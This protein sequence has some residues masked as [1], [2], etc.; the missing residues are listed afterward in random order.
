LLTAN[1]EKETTL[2]DIAQPDPA[3]PIIDRI[4]AN[5]ID[6]FRQF[7]GLPDTTFV[8]EEATWFVNANG[9]PGN[10][11]LRAQWDEAAAEQEIDRLL[12]RVARHATHMD[13]LVFPA[14]RPADL[15]RRLAERGL[16]GHTLGN[17]MLADLTGLAPAAPAPTGFSVRRVRDD[18]MLE[19]WK[20]VSSEGFGEDEQI[21]Y[22]AYVRHGYGPSAVSLQYIGYQEDQPVTSGTL[23]LS[24]GIPGLYDISTPPAARGRGYARALTVHMLQEATNLGFP[25][26]WTWAS[27]AGKRIYRS[28]G[29]IEHNFGIR[30]YPW[31]ASAST[32]R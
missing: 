27:D 3:L 1:H 24:D 12:R 14:C 20:N 11:I 8:E 13:W 23:L 21:F 9:A 18:A 22:D 2:P 17:W 10:H 32:D 26:V 15:G 30:E 28:V 6:Y 29:F 19:E 25:L 16:V 7:A 4:Q 31:E 5:F